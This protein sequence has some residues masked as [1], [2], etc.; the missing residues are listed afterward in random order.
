MAII[1]QSLKYNRIVIDTNTIIGVMGDN[2][3][4]FLKS[5]NGEVFYINNEVLLDNK[6]VLRYLGNYDRHIIEKNLKK[7]DLTKDFLEKKLCDLSHSESKLLKYLK[8]LV[9][10][11]KLIV[12]DEPFLDLDYHYKKV[13]ITLFNRLVKNKTIIIGSKN[14]NIIY[15]LCKKVLLLGK[16][17]YI[18]KDSSVLANKNVLKKYHLIMPEILEFIRLANSKKKHIPYSNDI[19]DLIKDVYKNA[20]K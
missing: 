9:L 2:Y 3:S 15:S 6:K 14:S 16:D 7:L 18:Y 12:V 19:R 4:E 11:T 1:L 10:D 17:D 20:T 13:I 5:L 8:M